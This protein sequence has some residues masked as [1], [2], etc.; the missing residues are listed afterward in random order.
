VAFYAHS[1]V[2]VSPK[3]TYM[4]NNLHRCRNNISRLW[5]SQFSR[6]PTGLFRFSPRRYLANL[7][8]AAPSSLEDVRWRRRAP[9]L[10]VLEEEVAAGPKIQPGWR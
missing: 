2:H 6:Q 8:M 10:P 9:R 5:S 4:S 3:T 1:G 7:G